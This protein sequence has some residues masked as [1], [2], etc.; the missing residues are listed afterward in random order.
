MQEGACIRI[1]GMKRTPNS[2]IQVAAV[3]WAI[4]FFGLGMLGGGHS[5]PLMP[6]PLD[7]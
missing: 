7:G 2:V 3:S 6:G 5:A 1:M 4:N